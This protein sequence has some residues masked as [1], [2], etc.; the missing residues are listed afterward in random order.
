[1]QPYSIFKKRQTTINHAFASAI[2]PTD[3]YDEKRIREAMVFLG[4]DTENLKC[5]YCDEPAETWDH[6]FGLVKDLNFSGSGHVIGNLLP[7]C[8]K[9]NSKKGNQNWEQF[10]NKKKDSKSSLKIS[11]FKKYFKKYPPKTIDL[12]ELE[13]SFYKEMNQLNAIK[14]K[15]IELMKKADEISKSVREKIKRKSEK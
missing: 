13:K 9:C 12:T 6:V 5:V 4:Q 2:A 8:K 15:V 14:D 1:L 7:C 3:I 10:L 11:L